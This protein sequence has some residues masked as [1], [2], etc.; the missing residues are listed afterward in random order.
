MVG[1]GSEGTSKSQPMPPRESQ[2]RARA[3]PRAPAGLPGPRTLREAASGTATYRRRRGA[4]PPARSG[5]NRPRHRSRGRRRCRGPAPGRR[6]PAPTSAS[7]R[8]RF[9]PLASSSILPPPA[10]SP[11]ST[12]KLT[13]IYT[14]RQGPPGRRERDSVERLPSHLGAHSDDPST[15]NWWSAAFKDDS[16]WPGGGGGPRGTGSSPTLLGSAQASRRSSPRPSSQVST[17]EEHRLA[18]GE[19]RRRALARGRAARRARGV[20]DPARR[21]QR[22]AL[23]VAQPRPPHRTTRRRCARTAAGCRRARPRSRAA[24]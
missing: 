13:A 6:G 5:P 1:N 7:R 12:P 4:R 8:Q 20:L 3:D 15:G 18:L 16:G 19:R 10:A 23:R 21:R 24:S 2:D 14:A 9:T 11:F 17:D 22:A